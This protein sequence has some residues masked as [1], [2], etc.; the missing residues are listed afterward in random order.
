MKSYIQ[1]RNSALKYNYG[2]TFNQFQDLLSKQ[3]NRCG[4]CDEKFTGIYPFKPCVDHIH[5]KDGTIR[6]ILCNKC[7]VAIGFLNDDIEIMKSAVK[8]LK[9]EGFKYTKVQGSFN[10]PIKR[11][12]NVKQKRA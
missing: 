5:D 12:K 3:K 11:I 4:I 1:V 9:N 6:G 8:W 2:I 10:P 7:N